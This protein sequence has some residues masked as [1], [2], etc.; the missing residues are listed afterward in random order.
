MYSIRKVYAF[1][2]KYKEFAER[3]GCK[4]KT[5]KIMEFNKSHKL[6][7]FRNIATYNI[8]LEI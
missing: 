4:I 3:L 5:C 7:Y 1:N 2:Y 8:S 6:K